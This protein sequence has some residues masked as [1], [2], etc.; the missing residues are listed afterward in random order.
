MEITS[1]EDPMK[2][3]IQASVPEKARYTCDITGG[4]LP[5]GPSATI[6]IRCGYGSPYDGS[7]FELDLSAEAAETL[8]PL[9][10]VLLVGAS[11]EPH[12]TEAFLNPGPM[13]ERR[14]TP[15]GRAKLIRQLG[16]IVSDQHLKSGVRRR[17]R[18][19]HG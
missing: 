7:V 11:L 19:A 8:L 14:I 13:R 6:V 4:A 10:R 5:N 1:D 15:S 12:R 3:I 9:I 17:K 16:K 2:H 18:R